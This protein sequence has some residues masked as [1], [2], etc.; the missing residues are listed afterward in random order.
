M[1]NALS[2]PSGS[3]EAVRTSDH[4][5]PDI[6]NNKPSLSTTQTLRVSFP[7]KP[8]VFLDIV[9]KRFTRSVAA[10]RPGLLAKLDRPAHGV[11]ALVLGFFLIA[12]R[13][14]AHAALTNSSTDLAV[15]VVT[16][17][18]NDAALP[19]IRQALDFLGTPY[20]VH[21]ASAQPGAL[22][23]D[24]LSLGLR[25]FYSSVMLTDS[26]LAYSPDGVSWTSALSTAEWATLNQ[27]SADFA[28][29]QINWS[30]YPTPDSGF[31]WPTAAFDST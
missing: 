21:I 29:R 22:T 25:G 23:A 11:L 15:L 5:Q 17:T 9:V 27:F 24:K 7:Q 31:N 2:I 20:T 3:E 14:A 26:Q 13:P 16:A 1:K 19:A 10:S 6:M 28:V 12:G 18:T 8:V 30:G 4:T